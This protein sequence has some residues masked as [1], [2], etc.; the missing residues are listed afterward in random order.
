MAIPK[1]TTPLVNG[2]QPP[3]SLRGL[4]TSVRPGS[5]AVF[6]LNAR[7]L[8]PGEFSNHCIETHGRLKRVHELSGNTASEIRLTGSNVEG[9][10]MNARV[11]IR[12]NVTLGSLFPRGGGLS[13]FND[14]ISIY[15][16]SGSRSTFYWSGSS[17][18]NASGNVSDAV[19][20][21][22]G[23][24]MLVYA[25]APRTLRMGPSRTS[26]SSFW[27]VRD[28]PLPV[29]IKARVPNFTG[30]MNPLWRIGGTV[31]LSDLGFAN[32]LRPFSDSLQYF[33]TDGSMRRE[34]TAFTTGSQ[35][36]NSAGQSADGVTLE[37]FEAMNLN[38]SQDT[39]ITLA[40]P[41]VVP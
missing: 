40:P 24:G 35:W 39:W 8:I 16:R 13:P 7:Q 36:V 18:I 23:Q 1:G 10:V 41:P 6:T 37:G 30:P 3:A 14:S 33:R 19:V 22:P 15:D 4:I 25:N 20:I 32:T 21:R 31:R 9:I 38:V 27:E 29:L 2:L 5:P 34:G 17:W 28:E 26:V 12:P 11:T